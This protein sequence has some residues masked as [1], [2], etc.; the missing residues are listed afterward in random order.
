LGFYLA[1]RVGASWLFALG[2]GW[3][4][5]LGLLAWGTAWRA[6]RRGDAV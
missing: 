6:F 1:H 4:A 3:P 5:G 2:V